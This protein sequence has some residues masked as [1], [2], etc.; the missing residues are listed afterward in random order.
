MYN[1]KAEL[2]KLISQGLS[3]KKIANRLGKSQ[4]TVRYWL[5][6]F[7][8]KTKRGVRGKHP[9]D[10]S[11]PYKCKCGEEDPGKFYGHKRSI[12][13]KCHNEYTLR[14]GQEKRSK[15]RALLGGKCT[16]CNFS[17]FKASLDIHHLDPKTKD[18]NF[19]TMRSWSW[20]RIEKEL[21]QCI[22]LCRNC[23]AAVHSGELKCIR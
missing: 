18:P 3:Q 10:F 16:L 15:A 19:N 8:L 23:H 7:E 11:L 9:K 5:K 2:L 14:K 17:K 21:E 1:M 12:C 13:G 4:S 20:K 6:K 22:L